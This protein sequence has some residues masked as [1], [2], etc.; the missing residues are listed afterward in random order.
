MHFALRYSRLTIGLSESNPIITQGASV[1]CMLL[2]VF[3]L[4][5]LK[6]NYNRRYY[7]CFYSEVQNRFKS[8]GVVVSEFT[9]CDLACLVLF[10]FLFLY[11]HPQAFPDNAARREVENLAAVCLN[12]GCTWKGSIKEYEV[13]YGFM[14]SRPQ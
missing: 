8:C 2:R 7:V 13:R 14:I 1:Y 11:V 10:S 3:I 12:E 9:V 5:R 4:N 6:R